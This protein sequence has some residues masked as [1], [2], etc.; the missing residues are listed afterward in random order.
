MKGGNMAKYC[1]VV[2][3]VQY[4]KGLKHPA[5]MRYDTKGNGIMKAFG[6]HGVGEW[7]VPPGVWIVHVEGELEH[8]LIPNDV[9]KK[10]YQ[11]IDQKGQQ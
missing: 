6:Y 9:F 7:T 2:E 5:I 4:Q 1:L 3:A 11:L 10:K 8:S